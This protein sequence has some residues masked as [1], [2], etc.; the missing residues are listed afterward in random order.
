MDKRVCI[1]DTYVDNCLSHVVSKCLSDVM[2][3]SNSC[4]FTFLF[5]CF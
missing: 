3:C 2:E 1:V 4:I 5:A